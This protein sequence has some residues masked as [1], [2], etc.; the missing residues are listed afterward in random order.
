LSAAAASI[1]LNDTLGD[2]EKYMN[3][4]DPEEMVTSW[5][6]YVTEQFSKLIDATTHQYLFFTLQKVRALRLED[7][8]KTAKD[9]PG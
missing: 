8:T 1:D 4:Y 9:R 3:H 7:R 2:G 6:E 5:D